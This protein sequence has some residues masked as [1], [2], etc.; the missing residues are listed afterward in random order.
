[1]QQPCLPEFRPSPAWQGSWSV[2]TGSMSLAAAADAGRSVYHERLLERPMMPSTAA[3]AGICAL[4]LLAPF[5]TM[6]PVGRLPGQSLSSVETVLL[7]VFGAWLL[8]NLWARVL[9]RWRTALTWPW[10]AFLAA[11]LVAALTGI[12]RLNGLHMAGRFA[13]AF[14]VYLVTVN[15]VSTLA[16]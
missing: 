5:D 4:I 1:M 10:M 14:G 11:M 2:I 16:R 15:G 13:L 9:P 12:D 3:W 7:A 6:Q 8:S